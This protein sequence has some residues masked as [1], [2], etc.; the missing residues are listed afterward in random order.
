MIRFAIL[1]AVST[2]EQARPDKIS[3]EYQE[4]SNRAAVEPLG[5]IETAG[6]FVID[7][8]SRSFYTNLS[9]AER[10][11]P[12]LHDALQA[13]R[14]GLY[15][16]LV[17]YTYDRLGDLTV[18]VSNEF[19]NLRKQIYSITQT[20]TIQEPEEYDPYSDESGA[21]QREIAAI[22]QRFRIN[23]LRRKWRA[24]M[25]KRIMDGLTPLRVPFGYRWVGK[26]EPPLLVEQEAALIYQMRDWLFMGLSMHE[27]ARRCDAT[28]IPPPNGGKR[29][30]VSSITYILANPYY[31]GQLILHRTRSLHDATRKNKYRPIAQPKSKWQTGQGKHPTLW[32]DAMHHSILRE[33]ERRHER[34]AGFALR[35]PLSGLLFCSVCDQKLHRR[36]YG[37]PGK[38]RSMFCCRYTPIH[39][40]VPYEETLKT[41]AYALFEALKEQQAQPASV[42]EDPAVHIQSALNELALRRKRIQNGYE[43]GLYTG[44]EATERLAEV[45]AATEKLR[46]Q[47]EQTQRDAEIAS[48]FKSSIT[49]QELD[50]L[51]EWILNDVPSVVNRTLVAL[52][53]K[54]ILTPE[55]QV[56]IIFR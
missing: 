45:N 31:A 17:I 10:D 25:P 21:I 33:L 48:E 53:K 44:P 47:L 52:C 13:A 12:P 4:K 30:D 24:G 14:A 5:W 37:A 46:S 51:P 23:D 1:T 29:W 26:K 35:F 28:H 6:P 9:D 16:V 55:G 56:R 22:T 43:T 42:S 41:V 2:P 7:G 8:Y 36:S 49:G 34:N 19:R 50:R 38:R 15:D 27:I 18:F 32:D 54:I 11:I 3:L 40:R 39:T 20:S